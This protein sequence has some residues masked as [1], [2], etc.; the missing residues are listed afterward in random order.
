M[1]EAL[2]ACM[3]RCRFVQANYSS[4]GVS[5]KKGCW[6]MMSRGLV[7]RL[8]TSEGISYIAGESAAPF[9]AS[10]TTE[11]SMRLKERAAWAA[12]RFEGVSIEEIRSITHRFFER[13][14]SQFQPT[15]RDWACD[16]RLPSASRISF[17]GPKKEANL[18]FTPGVNVICGASDTG[19]SFLAESIDF[20]LGGSTLKEILSG[21]HMAK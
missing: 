17:S 15:Q 14:M 18:A 4:G 5:S 1:L 20:M 21:Y 7:Q 19:K 12:E 3:C 13:W 16:R 2:Q 6:L 11:Y 10:L 8:P 9:L